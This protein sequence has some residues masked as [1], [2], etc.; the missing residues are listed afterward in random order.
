M[1][2]LIRVVLMVCKIM[3]GYSDDTSE[4]EEWFEGARRSVYKERLVGVAGFPFLLSLLV[5]SYSKASTTLNQL[6]FLHCLDF[7]DT[8]FEPWPWFRYPIL[9]TNITYIRLRPLQVASMSLTVA[10]M[11]SLR[12][13]IL[14]N[15]S[16]CSRLSERLALMIPNWM[17]SIA[18]I[19]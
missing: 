13:Q 12:S 1:V 7:L 11:F 15:F 16:A 14:T 17:A 4:H 3:V 8:N 10:A 9:V 19:Q 6:R 18:Q 5:L 2:V